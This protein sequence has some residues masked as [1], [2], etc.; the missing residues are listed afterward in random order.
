MAATGTT[1]APALSPG[2]PIDENGNG[3]IDASEINS[4]RMPWGWQV[5]VALRRGFRLLGRNFALAAE[6]R[7]VT[8]HRTSRLVYGATG[9]SDDDG[10]LDSADGQAYLRSL[11]ASANAFAQAYAERVDSPNR[12]DPG[13]TARATLSWLF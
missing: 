7:N 2:R 3:V 11:G 6:V 13:R 5:D 12:Y 9:E 1:P 8:N 10:W 4:E